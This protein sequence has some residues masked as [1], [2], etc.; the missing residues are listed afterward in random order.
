VGVKPIACG[1]SEIDI[2]QGG[3]TVKITGDGQTVTLPLG[4]TPSLSLLSSGQPVDATWSIQNQ[5]RDNM[6][7]PD[8]LF[9]SD[10]GLLFQ[11]SGPSDPALLA[12]LHLGHMQIQAQVGS[13]SFSFNVCT[14]NSVPLGSRAP[15]VDEAVYSNAELFGI[16]P[17]YIKGIIEKESTFTPRLTREEPR[18]WDYGEGQRSGFR[19]RL[20]DPVMARFAFQ[21]PAIAGVT[22]SPISEGS[23]V[24]AWKDERLYCRYGLALLYSWSVW[25]YGQG[26][27]SVSYGDDAIQAY[28]M[29]LGSDK[30][31][32]AVPPGSPYRTGPCGIGWDWFDPVHV[33][34]WIFDQLKPSGCAPREAALDFFYNNRGYNAQTLLSA[35][36]GYMQL[37][38]D[39]LNE[40]Q[41]L[42]QPNPTPEALEATDTNIGLGTMW[43]AKKRRYLPNYYGGSGRASLSDLQQYFIW[44]C[45]LFNGSQKKG[46][47]YG[48]EVVNTLAP[49]YQPWIA[50]GTVR[51]KP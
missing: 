47:G 8:D 7:N 21:E 3:Q 39:T 6:A 25:N 40:L 9:C 29:C 28:A 30:W 11:P 42:D 24:A 4:A 31:G 12:I 38:F 45:T 13:A 17:Q 10:V 43:L 35:S 15:E 49:A 41:W 18:T 16:P 51:R 20:T 27:T 32:T 1:I 37:S 23:L 36:Y 46:T 19:Q 48:Q 50:T 34:V 33:S 26:C 44:L 14:S 2:T 22:G 5:S